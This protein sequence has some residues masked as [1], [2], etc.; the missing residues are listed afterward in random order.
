MKRRVVITGMG[1]VTPIGSGLNQFWESLISGKNGIDTITKFDASEYTVKI[2]G[3]VKDFDPLKY[4]DKKEVKRM[5]PFT[6]F[7]LASCEMAIQD[8][9]IILEDENQDRM[10]VIV[11]SGIGGMKT[12]EN[13]CRVLIEKGPRRISPYFITMMISD[14]ASGLISM[15]YKLKGPNYAVT[16]ACATAS[17]AV[18]DAFRIIQAGDADIMIA[19]G[20]EA[21][22][23]PMSIGGFASMKALSTRND[24]P[25]R[26]SRPFDKMRDGFVMGEGAGILILE[27]MERA[28]KR[29]AK[30]Y[31]ELGGIGFTADAYHVTAPD[32]EGEGAAKAMQLAIND[33]RIDRNQVDY[34]NA[35]GTSTEYNDKTE[36]ASIKRV[37]GEHAYR[38][39][40]S[41]S[42]SMI[43]HL[44]GASGA[45]ELI[46]TIMA[47]KHNIIPPTI[48]YEYPDPECDLDYTPNKARRKT[49]KVALCNT[50]GFGGHNAV[51]LVKK[52]NT[53]N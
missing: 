42:K 39:C 48:N 33:A 16:S 25:G 4:L 29:K 30:I 6:Q 38:L 35:H 50:F 20:T 37:F 47:V 9:G 52:F 31:A 26:A 22:I 5:D 2:A 7:A 28:L 12:F 46:A 40:I 14:I 45:V 43:G 11:G 21:A 36:T 41:S 10:G 19:G 32:P 27:E 53:L 23:T 34:I 44:L 13:Q 1:A 51:I 15:R 18:G 24:E 49:V 8:S 17:H 3:E